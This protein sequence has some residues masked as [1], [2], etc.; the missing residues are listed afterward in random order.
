M[1]THDS[2]TS[3]VVS[4]FK[5]I[6]NAGKHVR[7]SLLALKLDPIFN[8]FCCQQLW[9][10]HKN[11]QFTLKRKGLGTHELA[12]Y[13]NGMSGHR[14]AM[15]QR[16]P[17]KHFSQHVVFSLTKKMSG[18]QIVWIFQQDNT[19]LSEA[20][21]LT[22]LFNQLLNLVINSIAKSMI[23]IEKPFGS[24]LWTHIICNRTLVVTVVPR[25]SS[26]S[27]VKESL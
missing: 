15:V 10:V 6:Q 13:I 5:L 26:K 4:E 16:H 23:H 11:R 24:N 12:S 21:L 25:V 3:N 20:N 8:P 14:Q 7:P 18:R 9:H 22:R 2:S 1:T 17:V 27:S 19:Y